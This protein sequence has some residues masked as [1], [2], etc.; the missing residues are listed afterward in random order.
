MRWLPLLLLVGCVDAGVLPGP[1]EG[2]DETPVVPLEWTASFDWQPC[3]VV[4]GGQ[5]ADAA[6]ATV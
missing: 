6:C 3:P 5:G 4:T 2:A 1:S